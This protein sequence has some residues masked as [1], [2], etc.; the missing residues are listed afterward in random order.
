MKN[1]LQ[2]GFNTS[3]VVVY[4]AHKW[5]ILWYVKFQYISCCSLSWFQHPVILHIARFN[6]SHVVVYHNRKIKNM[7]VL[8]V[9]IHLMLQFIVTLLLHTEK[10]SCFNTSH[11]VVYPSIPDEVIDFVERFQYIS[12]C[13]LSGCP[14]V[15][16]NALHVFQY[17]SCCSLSCQ[18]SDIIEIIP[19]FQYISCCSLST[20]SSSSY[21]YAGVS[22]HLMLQFIL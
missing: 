3:H 13:S 1:L 12:C 5:F 21:S 4:P 19:T 15:Q 16:K 22:I 17:I 18:P 8:T 14:V 11:V 7:E 9:S 10:K 20:P 6:T 2:N